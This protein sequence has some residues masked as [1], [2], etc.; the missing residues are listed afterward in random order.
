MIYAAKGDLKKAEEEYKTE[1]GIN[2]NYDDALY[3]YGLLLYKENRTEE[4]ENMWI[5]TLKVNPDYVSAIEN[6]FVVY[7]QNKNVEEANYYYGELQKRGIN[8]Q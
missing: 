5:E 8:L 1:L 3:N 4:A 6:L 2:P 7:Y